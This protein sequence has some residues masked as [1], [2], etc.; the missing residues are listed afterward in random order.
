MMKA[1]NHTSKLALITLSLTALA[2]SACSTTGGYNY[3]NLKDER[4][5][6]IAKLISRESLSQEPS[7]SL[8]TL[9]SRFKNAP[10]SEY[11]ATEYAIALRKAA[12][13][14]EAR[15]VLKDLAENKEATAPTKTEY[16]AI[17]IEEEK[18]DQAVKVAKQ[19]T[20]TDENYDMAFMVLGTALE[21]QEEHE[22]A[23]KAFRKA[24]ELW[25]GDKTTIM[26]TLALN[27]ASQ[28]RLNDA[29]EILQEAKALQ[30]EK[31]E[32]ERNLRIVMALKQSDGAQAPKP[33][34]KPKI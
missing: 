5:N 17:L 29:I 6:R 14:S 28:K 2:L 10:E 7:S 11:A 1:Y 30:P 34:T 27:L 13:Y 32:I 20:L 15:K 21:I 33:L 26:S 31:T 24:L 4:S 25:H 19:A 9:E 12:K 23:E 22:D 3:T 8:E 18:I 16:A